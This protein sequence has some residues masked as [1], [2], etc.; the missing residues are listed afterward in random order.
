MESNDK[1][2]H[3]AL[4]FDHLDLRNVMLPLMVLSTSHDANTNAVESYDTNTNAN[5]II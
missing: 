5:G 1:K 4:H 3:V 2:C